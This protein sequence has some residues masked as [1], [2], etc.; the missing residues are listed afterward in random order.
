VS[1][2]R[3][4]WLWRAVTVG[5]LL[6]VLTP[7]V[8][9]QW[10][11]LTGG[12]AGS[13]DADREAPCLPGQAVPLMASPH[14]AEAA[15]DVDYNSNPPTSGPHFG[16][17][18]APGIYDAPIPDGL[19]VHALEHGHIAIQYVP[20]TPAET[21]ADLRDVA[22]RHLNDVVLAPYPRLSDGIALTAWGR[23]DVLDSVDQHRITEFVDE[24]QGRYVHGWTR[25]DPC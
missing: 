23:I 21:V 7:F 9:A 5:G 17:T 18:V 19:T 13:R 11:A 6:A 20:D 8:H 3:R 1:E 10:D 25:P 2:R 22:R 14:I 4:R 15:A 12:V 16:F 24:L